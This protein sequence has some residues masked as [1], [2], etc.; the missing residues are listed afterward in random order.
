M[1]NFELHCCLNARRTINRRGD[2]CLVKVNLHLQCLSKC[3]N[4]YSYLNTTVGIASWAG[5][6]VGHLI[7]ELMTRQWIGS[8]SFKVGVGVDAEGPESSLFKAPMAF[9]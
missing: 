6:I 2:C 1:K 3:K 9:Y 7:A 5:S 8:S 4:S